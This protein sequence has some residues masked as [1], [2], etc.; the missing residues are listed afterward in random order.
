M[1]NLRK[2]RC[3]HCKTINS[4]DITSELKKHEINI[5]RDLTKVDIYNKN[6]PKSIK[7]TSPNPNK[8]LKINI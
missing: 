2:V 6:I 8:P 5:H 1:D 7:I 4:V 3:P